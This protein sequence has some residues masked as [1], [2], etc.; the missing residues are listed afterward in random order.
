[1]NEKQPQHAGETILVVSHDGLIR[2]WMCHMLGLP[3]YL[4]GN[5]QTDLCGLTEVDYLEEEQ[6]WRLLRFNQV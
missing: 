5:F 6:R 3:V 2:L 1:M 4:R